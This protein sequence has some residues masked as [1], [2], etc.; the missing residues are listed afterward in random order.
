[1]NCFCLFQLN[2]HLKHMTVYHRLFG[3]SELSTTHSLGS[4]LMES[5]RFFSESDYCAVSP[6]SSV[7]SLTEASC[8]CMMRIFVK[9]STIVPKLSIYNRILI[10]HI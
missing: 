6:L 5:L 8:L 10:A 3:T 4:S 2:N 1:M 7:A 9:Q